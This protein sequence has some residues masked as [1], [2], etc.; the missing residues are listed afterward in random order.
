M[1][2]DVL[3]CPALQCTRVFLDIFGQFELIFDVVSFL[4]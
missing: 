2:D 4:S 1:R 3:E